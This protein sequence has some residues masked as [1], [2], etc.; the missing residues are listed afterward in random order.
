[1]PVIPN[2]GR[3]PSRWPKDTRTATWSFPTGNWAVNM[4]DMVPILASMRDNLGADHILFA[5]DHPSRQALS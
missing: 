5:S 2:G 3:L 1:M 4:D